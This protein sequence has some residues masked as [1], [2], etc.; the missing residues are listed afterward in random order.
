M[1]LAALLVVAAAGAHAQVE[2][3]PTEHWA[4]SELEHFEMRGFVVLDGVRP[5]TRQHVRRYVEGL[6]AQADSF[7]RVEHQRLA[8]LQQ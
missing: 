1:L 3:L 2:T 4:Y 5:W 6:A 7:S 8:R